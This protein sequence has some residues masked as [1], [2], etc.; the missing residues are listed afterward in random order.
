MIKEIEINGFKCV[1][2]KDS[3][4]TWH[5]SA[6]VNGEIYPFI[7]WFGAGLD[8]LINQVRKALEYAKK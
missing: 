5:C 1:F 8:P 2:Q 6:H 3:N 4:G 7:D